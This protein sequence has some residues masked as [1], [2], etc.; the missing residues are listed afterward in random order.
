[1]QSIT[2]EKPYMTL[3]GNHDITCREPVIS[4]FCPNMEQN[5]GAYLHRW[6]MAGDEMGGFQ[7][8]RYS[9]DY[10]QVHFIILNTET[11]FPNAP[12]GQCSSHPER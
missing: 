9:F 10:G 2:A 7:N 11:D 4:S 6:Y 3:P 1:M 5:F 12:S 8:M